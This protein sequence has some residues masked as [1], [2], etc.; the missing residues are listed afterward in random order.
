M[1]LV[2][3]TGAAAVLGGVLG[4]AAVWPEASVAMP[5]PVI[6]HSPVKAGV[7]GQPILVRAVVSVEGGS[8][9]AVTLFYS[10][11]RDAAPF[12]AGMQDTGTGSY[13][14][15][16]PADMLAGQREITYYI[17]AVNA[18]DVGAETPWYRISVGGKG[19]AA[20]GEGGA[21]GPAWVKPALYGGGAAGLIGGAAW[22]LSSSSGGGG[23]GG[24]GTA[25]NAGTYAGSVTTVLEWPGETPVNT[26]HAMT[27]E[28]TSTG[29][30]RSDTIQ[31]GQYLMAPLSGSGFSL[32]G[33]IDE[34]DLTGVI[35][36]TGTLLD[37]RVVGSV[38]GTVRSDSGAQGSYSG[39]FHA[40][41]Q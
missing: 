28:V 29:E 12:K 22:L 37:D 30:V 1:R 4:L 25:T 16:I 23:Q 7:V 3:P 36:Y 38:D 24:G 41:R 34:S 11:S 18:A 13:L 10:L 5:A 31:E 19:G 20:E 39:T 33:T 32:V 8:V 27:I 6:R 9:K 2:G 26:S 21:G 40:V 15:T 14:G 17:E 35:R